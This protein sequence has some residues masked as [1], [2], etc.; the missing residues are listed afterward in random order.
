MKISILLLLITFDCIYSLNVPKNIEFDVETVF[1]DENN[2]EF[3]FYYDNNI[4]PLILKITPKNGSF[5]IY[6]KYP[7][8]SGTI[9][10]GGEYYKILTPDIGFYS[11][12]INTGKGTFMIHPMNT[13]IKID[14]T[15]QCYG[16]TQ[17]IYISGE[18][19]GPLKYLVSNLKENKLVNFTYGNTNQIIIHL[20]FAM[21]LNVLLV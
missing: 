20:K 18:Y 19:K 17:K 4:V 10:W 5:N 13:T 14:F 15:Q 11:L 8:Y 6:C 12:K 3:S 7:G 2:N 1:D 16:I 9:I 21:E